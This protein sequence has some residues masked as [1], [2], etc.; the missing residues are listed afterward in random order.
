MDNKVSQSKGVDEKTVITDKPQV[1]IITTT[2]NSIKYLDMCIQSVLHQ[3]YPYIEHVFVDGGSSDGTLK[4]L[5][6][7][8]DRYPD[9][10]VFISEPDK[11][12]CDAWNKGFKLARGDLLGWLGSDDMY[13]SDAI[14]TV[15]KFFKSNPDAYFVFGDCNILDEKHGIIKRFDA[16]DFDLEETIN[17]D[18]NV[19]APSAFYKR[20]VVEKIGLLD[21]SINSCDRD[22]WIRTGKAFQMHRIDKVLSNFRLHKDSV[23][24]SKAAIEIYSRE[25]YIVSRRHGGRIFSIHGIRYFGY[26][27]IVLLQPVMEL[28]Q[29]V[30][31]RLYPLIYHRVVYPCVRW[32][33]R[34]TKI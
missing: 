9:R 30:L 25:G 23:S 5:S 24:G 2:F 13:E 19:V 27:I 29:P 6:I 8:R 12:A 15:V 32:I 10:I 31:G 33:G 34:I 4:M 16:K 1:S 22:Y 11:N 17:G 3:S 20:E 7:Y 18:C 26:P 21:T 28:L 14:S